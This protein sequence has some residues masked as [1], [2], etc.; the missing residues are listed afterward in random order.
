M[1]ILSMANLYTLQQVDLF[2]QYTTVNN[3]K[4]ILSVADITSGAKSDSIFTLIKIFNQI[5]NHQ[6]YKADATIQSLYCCAIAVY[7]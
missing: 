2:N 5:L 6:V 1:Q 3:L 4:S 7:I